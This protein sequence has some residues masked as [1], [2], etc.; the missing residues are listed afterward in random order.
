MN[1]ICPFSWHLYNT[2][3][4]QPSRDDFAFGNDDDDSRDEK[5]ILTVDGSPSWIS[6]G[7]INKDDVILLN[8]FLYG[9]LDQD[10]NISGIET[11]I[12]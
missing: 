6:A 10:G 5:L 3:H 7:D 8:G 2:F 12:W 11:A 1:H 4:L 9:N